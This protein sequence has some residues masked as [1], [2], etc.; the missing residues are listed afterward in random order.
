MKKK[1]TSTSI[2]MTIILIVLIVLDVKLNFKFTTYATTHYV[3]KIEILTDI[4]LYLIVVFDIFFVIY[5]F[6]Y[7]SMFKDNKTVTIIGLILLIITILFSFNR[8]SLPLIDVENI[9]SVQNLFIL[10]LLVIYTI[11]LIKKRNKK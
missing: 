3:D 11:N 4:Y 7:Y 2:I 6:K 5:F 1:K 8:L 10:L 9:L